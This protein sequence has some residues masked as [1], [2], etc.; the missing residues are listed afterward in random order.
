MPH[1]DFGHAFS[2]SDDRAP[3]VVE[4]AQDRPKDAL[5][6]QASAAGKFPIHAR[7]GRSE[8]ANIIFASVTFTGGL[9]CAFYFFNGAE[10]LRAAAAWPDEFLYSRPV[11]FAQNVGIERLHPIAEQPLPFRA[12]P[13]SSAPGGDPFSRTDPLTS[14]STPSNVAP[15]GVGAGLPSTALPPP[16]VTP[17]GPGLPPPPVGG[18]PP[19][20]PPPVPGV[21]PP[22]VTAPNPGGLL[23]HLGLPVPGGDQLARTFDRAVTELARIT[24]VNRT[25]VV[26][27]TPVTRIE[28]PVA[29]RGR[30]GLL[31]GQRE[32]GV[33]SAIGRVKGAKGSVTAG[34][35]G[36]A[37][38]QANATGA[39]ANSAASSTSSSAT[40]TVNSTS[41]T[42]NSSASSVIQAANSTANSTLNTVNGAAST[43]MN[44]VR[45]TLGNPSGALGGF[46][47]PVSVG[48]GGHH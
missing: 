24:N 30:N 46:H 32:R 48:G 29:A 23:D 20:A 8:W 13:D 43:G 39:T 15:S 28:R 2:T 44:T 16:T 25:V 7:L 22:P 6:L 12:N 21:V 3:L 33:S 11:A 38:D 41:T 45:G 5:Y 10:L 1:I 26:I 42:A 9:F 35:A 31:N 37:Q 18:P 40:S 34:T 17:G 36:T 47:A 27:K 19:V 14:L 4:C